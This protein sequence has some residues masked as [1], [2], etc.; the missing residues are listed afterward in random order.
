MSS[1]GNVIII[2]IGSFYITSQN[3]KGLK[4]I[5]YLEFTCY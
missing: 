4:Y 2:L 3:Y 5:N 1:Q